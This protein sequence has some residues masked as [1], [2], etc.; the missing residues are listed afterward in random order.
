MESMNGAGKAE[1]APYLLTRINARMSRQVPSAWERMSM[2]I[3]RPGVAFA[4]LAFIVMVNILIYR[5]DN[6]ADI[7]V[8]NTSA[9]SEDYSLNTSTALFDLENIQQP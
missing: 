6:T 3:A 8:V 5:Y 1:A 2:F 9:S 4:I 7:S